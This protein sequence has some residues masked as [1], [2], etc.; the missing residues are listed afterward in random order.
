MK[1]AGPIIAI[2]LILALLGVAA[3]VGVRSVYLHKN[4]H[5]YGKSDRLSEYKSEWVSTKI[6]SAY[7][8]PI[9]VIKHTFSY[10]IPTGTE[11]YYMALTEDNVVIIVR[12]GKKWLEKNFDAEG[13]AKNG[14]LSL[15]GYVRKL[16]GDPVVVV[17]KMNLSV[18]FEKEYF[19]DADGMLNGILMAILGLLPFVMGIV[20]VVLYRSGALDL[21]LNSSGAKTF[22]LIFFVLM[23]VEI[24]IMLHVF[25]MV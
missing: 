14:A 18:R 4:P 1:K 12:A 21:E 15:N 10:I 17:G 13:N 23:L 24:G 11:Y 3:F 25:S 9:C 6:V 7:M 20:C 19:L 5:A 16:S 8:E 22:F 2:V